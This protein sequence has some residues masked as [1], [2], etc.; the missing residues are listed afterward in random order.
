M[1]SACL[2]V[3]LRL[4]ILCTRELEPLESWVPNRNKM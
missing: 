2:E 1:I 4:G 3:D